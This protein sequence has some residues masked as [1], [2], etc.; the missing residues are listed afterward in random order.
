MGYDLSHIPSCL[1]PQLTDWA[2]RVND[3]QKPE[4]PNCESAMLWYDFAV[5]VM[6]SCHHYTDSHPD[7]QDRHIVTC[8]DMQYSVQ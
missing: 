3:Q 6:R 5:P 4:H 8:I 2:Y 1:F 7:I